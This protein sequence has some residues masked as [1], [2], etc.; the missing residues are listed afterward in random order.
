MIVTGGGR[1]IGAAISRRAGE[2]GYSVAVNYTQAKDRAEEVVSD[3]EKAG[4]RAIAVQAD[5]GREDD[6]IRLLDVV[7]QELGTGSAV[8]NNAATDYVTMIKDIE[9]E[10]LQRAFSVNVFGLFII[11]REAVKRMSTK[12]GGHGG[13]IVNV[14]SIS[15]RYGGLP[16]DVTYSSYK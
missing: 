16:G 5:M 9:L 8:V 14:G 10:G 13:S 2:R 1:G 3:I 12:L 15:A 7:D 11:A 4:G 6:V